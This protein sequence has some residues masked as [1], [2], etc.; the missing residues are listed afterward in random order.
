MEAIA[1]VT[2]VALLQ[3]FVFG[4]QVGQMRMKHGVPAPATSGHPEFDRMFRVQQ[5]TLESL[6]MFV[7]ALWLFG[8]YVSETWGALV[9]I[10]FVFGRWL[11]KRAYVSDPKRR[12][13]G[14]GISTS[15]TAIL[16]IGT[17]IAVSWRLVA[18]YLG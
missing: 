9:G 15:A 14:F 17:L 1:I 3:F 7:P 5:N 18:P 13:P 16:L 11:Y 10:A 2:I 6:I 12:G 4:F 8:W